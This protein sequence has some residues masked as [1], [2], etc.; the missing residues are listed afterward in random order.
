[1]RAMVSAMV[2][3]N[4]VPPDDV[5]V[6]PFDNSRADIMDWVDEDDGG[7]STEGGELDD[8]VRTAYEHVILL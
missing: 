1:M 2:D 3:A 7:T 6:N 5:Q 4:R 8:A